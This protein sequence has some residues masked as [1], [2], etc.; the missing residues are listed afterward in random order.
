MGCKAVGS[1]KRYFR[2]LMEAMGI[3]C[4]FASPLIIYF[5]DM[6]K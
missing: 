2:E 6:P 4:L 3:A 5:I 1:M